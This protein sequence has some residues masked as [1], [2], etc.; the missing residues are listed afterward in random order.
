MA[1]ICPKCGYERHPDDQA[2]ETECPHCG[3]IYAKAKPR[4]QQ[5]PPQPTTSRFRP[6]R[7]EEESTEAPTLDEV[8]SLVTRWISVKGNKILLGAVAVSFVVGFFAG[9]EHLKYQISSSIADAAAKFSRALGGK[10]DSQ[11]APP[12]KPKRVSTEPS[13]VTAKL[14]SKGFRE[15]QYG[16]NTVTFSIDFTNTTGKDVRAFDG[17]LAFTDLLGNVLH[18]ATLAVNDRIAKGAT[19]TWDGALSYNEFLPTHRTLRNAETENMKVV[20]TVRRVMFED[21]Q[22]KDYE[23]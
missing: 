19:L 22:T 23:R 15:G 21:G 8:R 7:I 16:R 9:R 3:V 1:T 5:P 13:P 11:P 2:P 20:F 6:S 4:G 10:G 17:K 12:P 14:L 18:E